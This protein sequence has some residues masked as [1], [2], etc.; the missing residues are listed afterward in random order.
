[1]RA[2]AGLAAALLRRE[3]F[4]RARRR[5]A[6]DR[7]AA[8]RRGRDR[9]DPAHGAGDDARQP[10]HRRA[11]ARRS[12][13]ARQVRRA[14]AGGARARARRSRP[15]RTMRNA[16]LLAALALAAAPLAAQLVP[17]PKPQIGIGKPAF[18]VLAGVATLEP[19]PGMHLLDLKETA[20][21]REE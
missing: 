5:V 7:G 19:P 3:G 11:V 17:A 15:G 12:R 14:H 6:D 20:R 13:R 9:G 16:P 4:A 18:I 8:R 21:V 10:P 1:A 2:R